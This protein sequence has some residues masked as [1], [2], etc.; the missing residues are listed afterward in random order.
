[1]KRIIAYKGFRRGLVCMG[2]QFVMGKNVTKEANCR[3]NGFHCAENPLD[4]LR[5][6]SNMKDSEY[7]LV[8]PGGD[9]DEDEIDSKIACTELTIVKRLDKKEFFTHALAYMMDH[10]ARRWS[11]FVQKERGVAH[12]DYVVVRGKNPLARGKKGDILALAKEAPDANTVIQIALT[13]VDGRTILPDTWYD[14]DLQA[15]GDMST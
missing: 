14:I 15:K 13:Q 9:Q 8:I 7:C 1:M 10:P 11:S 5:Y 6:Y 4:C 3:E 12:G 2:Y